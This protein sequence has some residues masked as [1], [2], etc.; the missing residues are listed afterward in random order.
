MKSS[1]SSSDNIEP[2]SLATG[3]LGA[4]TR[5]GSGT[6]LRLKK[7]NALHALL[8][9]QNP[10]KT[11]HLWGRR[12]LTKLPLAGCGRVPGALGVL[13][14]SVL[15]EGTLRQIPCAGQDNFSSP[16]TAPNFWCASRLSLTSEISA[17]ISPCTYARASV[18]ID[19]FAGEPPAT[20]QSGLSASVACRL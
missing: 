17:V 19:H 3:A 6:H 4:V 20:N 11:T 16:A 1:D 15:G 5:Q 14:G 8:L 9:Q 12:L 13:W 18:A 10:P 7:H 2:N